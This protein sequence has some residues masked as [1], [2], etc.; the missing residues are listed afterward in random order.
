[1]AG[2]AAAWYLTPAGMT[3]QT[4]QLC[5]L[6]RKML[7]HLTSVF[8]MSASQLVSHLTEATKQTPTNKNC[9]ADTSPKMTGYLHY[10]RCL[11]YSH[12]K[13]FLVAAFISIVLMFLVK[14]LTR[15]SSCPPTINSKLQPYL[16]VLSWRFLEHQ[17]AVAC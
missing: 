8:Y 1:M 15:Q 6:Q 9:P 2:G 5:Q 14:H 4:R 10:C 13:M 3:L 12:C 11:Q 7:F 16:S 17:L